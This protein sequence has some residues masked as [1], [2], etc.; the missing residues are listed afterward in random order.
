MLD[1]A[2]VIQCWDEGFKK[3]PIGS[4][5]TINCPSE[6]GYGEVMKPGIPENSDL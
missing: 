6:M 3:V 5:A 2:E 4:K 1:Q